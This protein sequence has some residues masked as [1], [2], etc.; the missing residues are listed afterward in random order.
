MSEPRGSCPSIRRSPSS[1]SSLL[2]VVAT[3]GGPALATAAPT[4]A[5][6]DLGAARSASPGVAS[7]AP[8]APPTVEP[9]WQPLFDGK[10]LTGWVQKGGNA[11]YT[12]KDKAI[13]GQSVPNTKNSFLSTTRS[14]GDFILELDFKVDPKLNSG[15]QI[16]GQSSPD[17]QDGRVHGYQIEIDPDVAR[18]RMWTGGLYDEGRRG[19]L[20]EVTDNP[21]AKSAFRAEDWNHMRIEAVG[22]SF[23][24]F[25][26]DV[27]VVDTVD[28]MDLEGFIGLQVHQ[29]GKREE[30]YYVSW[31][32]IR[33]KDLGR[34]AWR[35]LLGSK[36]LAGFH[37]T[38]GGTW[39]VEPGAGATA[40]P[41]IVGTNT[42]AEPRAGLLFFDTPLGD[43]T[44][45]AQV[46][47]GG[48]NAGIY[49]GAKP[50]ASVA[51][52]RGLQ[53]DV[54]AAAGAGGLFETGGR[55][56]LVRNPSRSSARAPKPAA[57]NPDAGADAAASADAPDA[58]RAEPAEKD[59]R[60]SKAAAAFKPGE[61]TSVMVVARGS[62]VTTYVGG[63]RAA[64]LHDLAREKTG[65]LALEINGGQDVRLEVKNLEVLS[66]QI[67][68]PVPGHPIGWCIR[69]KGSAPDDA[70]AA[71]FEYVEVALQDVLDLPD[72]AFAETVE[73]FRA[74]GIPVRTGYNFL[75]DDL[76]IIGPEA[77]HT[78]EAA[79]LA[80]ALPRVAKL[81]IK[82]IIFNSGPA[83][84]APDG[85]AADKAW[86]DLVG[87]SQRFARAARA[88]GITILVIPLRSTDTNLV[89]KVDEALD[90]IKAVAAPNFALAVDYSFLTIEKESPAVLRKA[91]KK[92][93]HVQISNPN[94]RGY[95]MA[96]D[97]AD[98]AALFSVLADLHYDGALSVHGRTDNF[99]ADAPRTLRFLRLSA[100]TLLP[101]KA[102]RAAHP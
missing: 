91:G 34:R 101:A 94:G 55:G 9:P 17:Y 52:A 41:I 43:F 12:V 2:L 60:R 81:G 92:L 46:R 25:L 8:T 56:W 3:L 102:P 84:R 44:A 69:G 37:A 61:W 5:G 87:F 96:A 45:R 35:P 20:A 70:K 30:P 47:L 10:T 16:R 62:D 82:T 89:T 27:P 13:V 36:G 64:Q 63:Y 73:R 57:A 74:L 15:I 76:K 59:E 72:A 86:K 11:K 79:Y 21:A 29:V 32:N 58:G 28:P 24:T 14:Y 38:G 48:G 1:L 18:G 50:A 66:D 6:A 19:W 54:D 99:F 22:D 85:L 100:A 51:G 31:R 75:P 26:N 65:Q 68:P 67:P 71:G 53:I 49:L 33:I 93:R 4:D 90:L 77:D 23:K 83:R 42:R 88:H 7:P 40:D 95:A 78:R 98:Y 80:R 39:K 97:E